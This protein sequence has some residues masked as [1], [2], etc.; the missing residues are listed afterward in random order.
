MRHTHLTREVAL[1]LP[2]ALLVAAAFLSI[3]TAPPAKACDA[4]NWYDPTHQVCAP[5][6]PA[7]PPP[8]YPP[9]PNIPYPPAQWPSGGYR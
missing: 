3:W 8:N 7:Y 2:S 4:G 5:Y 6:P 9:P 1:G